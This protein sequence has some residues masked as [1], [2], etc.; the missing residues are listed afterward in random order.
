MKNCTRLFLVQ[1]F[2][3]AE[4]PTPMFEFA[5]PLFLFRFSWPSFEFTSP[6][7]EL[8]STFCSLTLQGHIYSQTNMAVQIYAK[9][10]RGRI[11]YSLFDY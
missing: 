3:L 1:F 7:I 8:P 9:R 10:T 6:T 2:C 4:T 11:V 5:L